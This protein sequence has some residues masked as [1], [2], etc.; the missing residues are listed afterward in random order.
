MM[1]TTIHESMRQL[2]LM[3]RVVTQSSFGFQPVPTAEL[4]AEIMVTSQ[5]SANEDSD[6]ETKAEDEDDI[7]P[8]FGPRPDMSSP[9]FD[10][11]AELDCLPFKLNLGEAP[12]S[13]EQQTRLI[14]IIYNSQ[15]V[16]LF[17]DGDLGYCDKLKHSIPLT[18]DKPVYLS[19]RT[20]PVQLQAEVQ[21]CLDTW[22]KQG[23][24][25]PSKHILS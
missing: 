12:F 8:K 19:H 22:L 25:R 11:K 4:Q 21:K 24:I 5:E 23:I 10:F 2:L 6:G 20:I 3:R 17:H 13:R 9:D 14:D 15:S 18:T 7:K 16:F 1:W